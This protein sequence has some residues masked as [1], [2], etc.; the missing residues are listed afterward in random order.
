MPEPL[1]AARNLIQSRLADLDAE[2]KRLERALA[3]L[4]EG[5]APRS[6]RPGRPRKRAAAATSAPPKPKRSLA[7]KRR[8]TKRA[9]RGHRREQLLAAIKASPGARPSELAR[10]IGVKSTQ[11]HALIAKARAEK[12]IV[13]RGKGFALKG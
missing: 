13:K 8:A 2:A 10:S 12:L 3:G 1:D 9:P 7:R 4:G 5:R 6:R 11:V